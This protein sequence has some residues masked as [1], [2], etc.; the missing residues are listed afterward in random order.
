[1][2]CRVISRFGL[3]V[4]QDYRRQV[5]AGVLED[6]QDGRCVAAGPAQEDDRAGWLRNVGR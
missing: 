5:D 1:M 2:R 4:R 3:R 6:G